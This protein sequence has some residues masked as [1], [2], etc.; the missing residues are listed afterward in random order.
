LT[1]LLPQTPCASFLAQPADFFKG[2]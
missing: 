1:K 2:L